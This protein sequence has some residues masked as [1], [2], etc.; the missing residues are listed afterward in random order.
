MQR[1]RLVAVKTDTALHEKEMVGQEPR[2][3]GRQ[4]REGC[5]TV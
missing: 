1:L 5:G 2:G 4:E 3:D